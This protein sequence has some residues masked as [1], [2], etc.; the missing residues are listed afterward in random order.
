MFIFGS[1]FFFPLCRWFSLRERIQRD[2]NEE[3]AS[4]KLKRCYET[5]VYI[6]MEPKAFLKCIFSWSISNVVDSTCFIHS[7][8]FCV[9]VCVCVWLLFALSPFHTLKIL[10]LQIAMLIL[11]SSLLVFVV[12]LL[13]LSP[14]SQFRFHA[15]FSSLFI[16]LFHFF[17]CVMLVLPLTLLL[18]VS[19]LTCSLPRIRFFLPW[20]FFSC[21]TVHTVKMLERRLFQIEYKKNDSIHYV[22]EQEHFAV[23]FSTT[24]QCVFFAPFFCVRF[25]NH[26]STIF[27]IVFRDR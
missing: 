8:R 3:R 27:L 21:S 15:F 12:A 10:L 24:V 23:T 11:F 1:E 7:F 13:L 17:P 9:C 5:R 25:S 26:L 2:R 18:H 4:P 20:L 19:V 6:C 14:F 16:F 22:L